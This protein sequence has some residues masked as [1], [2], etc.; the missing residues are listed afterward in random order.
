MSRTFGP[1]TKKKFVIDPDYMT[2]KSY[3]F[4]GF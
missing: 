3:C 2:A 4:I 1:I